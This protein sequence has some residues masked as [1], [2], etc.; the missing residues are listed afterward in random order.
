ML[1]EKT[2]QLSTQNSI[3]S[4]NKSEVKTFPTNKNWENKLQ[5]HLSNKKLLKEIIQRELIAEQR[6]KEKKTCFWTKK[7]QSPERT[8]SYF[9][10]SKEN[11]L[12]TGKK[13]ARC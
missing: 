10:C 1:Q 6:K 2:K 4:G 9:N 12:P 5:A 7:G 8:F 3:P 11:W 13:L